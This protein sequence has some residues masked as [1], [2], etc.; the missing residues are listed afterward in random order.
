MEALVLAAAIGTVR[1]IGADAYATATVVPASIYALIGGG[2]FTSFLVPQIVRASRGTDQGQA[3]VNKLLSLAAV[4]FAVV[5]VL[6]TALSPLLMFVYGQR[7]PGWVLACGL[8]LWSFPQVFFLGLS[9]VLG[10]VLNA[11]RVF[12]WST[13][14]PVA[15][16]VVGIAGLALF[17][18]LFGAVG[19]RDAAGYSTLAVVV[20]GASG[21]AGVAVQVLVLMLGWR[22]SGPRFRPDF[23]WRSVGLAATGRTG[24]WTIAMLAS[25]Q[26]VGLLQAAV[27]NQAA[28]VGPSTGA[29]GYAWLIF[30]L[31]HSLVTVS[32]LTVFYPR[33]SSAAASEDAAAFRSILS[34]TIRT[35]LPLIALAN[36]ALLVAAEPIARLLTH[37][38]RDAQALAVIID[39]YLLGLV[40]FTI[41]AIVQR[42]FY[43]LGD[44]RTPFLYTLVQVAIVG[45]GFA[46]TALLPLIAAATTAAGIVQASLAWRLLRKRMGRVLLGLRASTRSIGTAATGALLVGGLA[47][48]AANGTLG[49]DAILAAW[50]PAL[51]AAAVLAVL[52][53][54]AYLTGLKLTGSVALQEAS[55]RLRSVA[56]R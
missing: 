36:V 24:G 46:V 20:L 43:A 4:G 25:T 26:L 53:T 41:L 19:H 29:L 48:V 50:P 1:S 3:Y 52:T 45:A 14:A 7:G 51:A 2:L 30:M 33:L 44:T 5:A 6:A 21:L 37:G 54:A 34:R 18:V 32:L 56:T 39:V 12:G 16:N 31:P 28:G 10:E 15:N 47:L 22:V 35:V 27:A 11:R 40:P 13:W 9:A 55:T 17:V 8:A 38:P 23:R 42:C 49:T